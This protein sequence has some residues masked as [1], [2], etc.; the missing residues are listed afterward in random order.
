MTRTTTPLSDAEIKRA[1]PKEK[2][3]TLADG[4]GLLLRLTSKGSKTWFFNYPHPY[5]N[6]R[7]K[8]NFGVYP[9]VSLANVRKEREAAKV[10]LSQNIDPKNHSDSEKRARAADY[11]IT[12]TATIVGTQPTELASMLAPLE[13]NGGATK[14]HALVIGSPAISA[15]DTS[16]CPKQDQ[17]GEPRELDGLFFPVMTANNKAAIISLDGDCDIGS[18]E[19]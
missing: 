8:I 12:L 15:A 18:F 16:V 14:T 1:K 2:E 17:R 3:Y 4:G 5:T 19:E 9:T 6:K 13:N 10:V 11:T 7:N